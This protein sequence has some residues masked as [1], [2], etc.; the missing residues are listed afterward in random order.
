MRI[1]APSLAKFIGTVKEYR[2]RR[3][4]KHRFPKY[5]LSVNP[6]IPLLLTASGSRFA[7]SGSDAVLLSIA[8]P[9]P[10]VF[11]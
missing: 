5:Q 11:S 2:S 9:C 6:E 3:I 8:R 1:A 7:Y 4:F 10:P